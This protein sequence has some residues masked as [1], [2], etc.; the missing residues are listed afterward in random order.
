MVFWAIKKYFKELRKSLREG[1]KHLRKSLPGIV[2]GLG[3]HSFVGF[4]KIFQ[5]SQKYFLRFLKNIKLW[6][7]AFSGNGLINWNILTEKK[8]FLIKTLPFFSF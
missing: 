1:V 8:M 7:T 2:K 5:R 4:W 6:I 3:G